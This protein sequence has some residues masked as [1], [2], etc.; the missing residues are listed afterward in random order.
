[1]RKNIVQLL[2][3]L[4]AFS[5]LGACSP[6]EKPEEEPAPKYEFR[7]DGNL[8]IISPDGKIKTSFKIEIVVSE[9]EVMRGMKYRDKLDKDQGMLFIFPVP[10]YY[11][12]WMQDTYLPLDML[13]I[14]ADETIFQI[15]E[16]AV[17]FSEDRISP[18]KPNNYVL[19]INAGIAKELKIK[20]GDKISWKRLQ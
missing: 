12:F 6:K 5:I 4:M 10:D 16:N 2:L 20:T 3:L 17:P 9:A 18:E 7:H 11:D 15:H 1:M 13:F 8:D 19:E 14:S